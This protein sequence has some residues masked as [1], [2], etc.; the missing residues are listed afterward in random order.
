VETDSLG[1]PLLIDGVRVG[2]TPMNVAVR[3]VRNPK[4]RVGEGDFAFESEVA[5]GASPYTKVQVKTTRQRGPAAPSRDVLERDLSPT[6]PMIPTVPP[7]PVAPGPRKI[8]KSLLLGGV[9]GAVTAAATS[10]LCA[11]RATAPSPFGGVSGSTYL[12][13]GT[14]SSSVRSNC[15]GVSFGSGAIA[16]VLP[17][18]WLRGKISVKQKT[19]YAAQ[20]AEYARA[21]AAR[22][23]AEARRATIVDSAMSVRETAA[24]RITISRKIEVEPA[25]I[26]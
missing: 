7:V 4:L 26:R 3:K 12:P 2:S 22:A 5:L 15:M 21:V 6:L 20:Q 8:G 10:S 13:P 9:V 17:L 19:A 18:H 11:S 25:V 16:S 24:R 1:E 23:T 14:V